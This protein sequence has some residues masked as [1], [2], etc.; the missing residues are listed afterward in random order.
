M[1][2]WSL[3]VCRGIRSLRII[4][5]LVCSQQEN[6]NES[7]IDSSQIVSAPGYL[8]SGPSRINTLNAPS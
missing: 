7:F 2:V 6:F 4:L 3:A 5:A 8:S 1:G